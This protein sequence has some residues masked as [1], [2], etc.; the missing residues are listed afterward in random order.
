M[1]A[2]SSVRGSMSGGGVV[3]KREPG[4][5]RCRVREGAWVAMV[6]SARGGLAGGGVVSEREHG[7]PRCRLRKGRVCFGVCV[8]EREILVQL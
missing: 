2:V 3:C 8:C 7:R 6:S 5:R 4:W 1:A